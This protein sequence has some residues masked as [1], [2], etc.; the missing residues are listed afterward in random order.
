MVGSGRL[1]PPMGSGHTCHVGR[2]F[3]LRIIGACIVLFLCFEGMAD[4]FAPTA[5]HLCLGKGLGRVLGAEK[6]VSLQGKRPMPFKLVRMSSLGAMGNTGV[7]KGGL[8]GGAGGS[9]SPEYRAA[10]LRCRGTAFVP[11]ESMTVLRMTKGTT[12]MKSVERET[13]GEKEGWAGWGEV[14]LKDYL[15]RDLPVQKRGGDVEEHVGGDI[16]MCPFSCV[17]IFV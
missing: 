2:H 15:A 6:S 7:C 5:S 17:P 8:G 12:R 16:G 1:M 11:L 4:A 14:E 10:W 13:D 3:G 9:V